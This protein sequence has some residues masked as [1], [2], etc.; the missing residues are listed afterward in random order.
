MSDKIVITGNNLTIQKLDNAM[1]RQSAILIKPNYAGEE[2]TASDGYHTFE[3]LYDHR[4]ELFIA[5]CKVSQP[6]YTEINPPLVWRSKLHY[7]GSEFIGWFVLGMNKVAGR[8][9]TYH[10]PM[11]R[12]ADTDFAE[13][14]DKAPEFDGH[15]PA[16]VLERLKRL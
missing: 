2:V 3:E 16:D 7:D 5:L 12:W 9:I 1:T 15:T 8:Q 14:L 11:V 10:L 4:I 13:T 6:P